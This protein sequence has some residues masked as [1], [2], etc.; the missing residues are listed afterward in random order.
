MSDVGIVVE[1]QQATIE[2]IDDHAVVVIENAARELVETV[3]NIT[4]VL[5]SDD[6]DI[7]SVGDQGPSGPPGIPESEMIYAE[8]TDFVGD[9]V[10]YRGYAIPGV[11][12]AQ[13][14]WRIKKVIIGVDGDITT[15]WADG[16]GD[17]DNVW[18]NHATLSYA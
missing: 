13:P 7:I 3:E 8:R 16:N 18:A 2:L 4:V 6:A 9:D 14:I 1:L 17:F 10:I 5:Q 11:T 15:T 12:D